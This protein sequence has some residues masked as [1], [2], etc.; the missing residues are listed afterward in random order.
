ME[1]ISFPAT[2]MPSRW[3]P[4]HQ[5]DAALHGAWTPAQR[6]SWA[7]ARGQALNGRLSQASPAAALETPTE[8]M[9]STAAALAALAG[10]LSL[11]FGAPK[12]ATTLSWVGILTATIGGLK[13][14]QTGSKLA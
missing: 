10:G 7:A 14:L 3:R 2:S 4:D 12:G 9:V 6:Q 1:F 13:L 8:L 5:I 11:A